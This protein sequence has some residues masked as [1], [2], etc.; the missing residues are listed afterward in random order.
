[1]HLEMRPHNEGRVTNLFSTLWEPYEF[2][3]IRSGLEGSSADK[4]GVV[5]VDAQH[6]FEEAFKA[7][8]WRSIVNY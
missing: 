5:Q 6:K 8:S 2:I 3:C 1:M 4:R 7:H